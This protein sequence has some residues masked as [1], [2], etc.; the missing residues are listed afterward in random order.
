MTKFFFLFLVSIFFTFSVNAQ[1]NLDSI[2]TH[3]YWQVYNKTFSRNL[4]KWKPKGVIVFS[5]SLIFNK[6]DNY[7]LRGINRMDIAKEYGKYNIFNSLWVELED[8]VKVLNIGDSTLYEIT[9]YT[10]YLNKEKSWVPS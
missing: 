9:I 10:L 4:F 2:F 7:K 5:D 1:C 8:T 6:K 3:Y